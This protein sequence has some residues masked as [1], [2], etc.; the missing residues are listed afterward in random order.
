MRLSEISIRNFRRLEDVRFELD[1]EATLLVGPNNSGKTS[2]TAVFRCFLG[3]RAFSVHD[4]SVTRAQE[5]RAFGAAEGAGRL[6][7]IELDLWFAVDP[8]S[9]GYARSFPLLPRLSADLDRL[10]LRLA[11]GVRD[12]DELRGEFDSYSPAVDGVRSRDLPQF[13]ALG[14]NL[15]RHFQT[16][17]YSITEHESQPDPPE[18]SPEE[19]KKLLH[20]LLRVDFVDAQRMIDDAD[21]SRSNKLSDA[22]AG[23]YTRNL[24]QAEARAA[25]TE[26]IEANNSRLTEHYGEQFRPLIETIRGLGV[27]SV[28][29]REI[30]I[31]SSLSP[32]AA[33]RGNTDLLYVDAAR[34]HELPELYN[35]LGFKN[36]IYMA[37]QARDYQSQWMRTAEDRSLIQLLFIEEPEVHLH[38]QVQQVFI[39]NVQKVLKECA[40]SAGEPA[41]VPQVIITTHSSHIVNTVDFAKVRYFRRCP[42]AG[43]TGLQGVLNASEVVSLKSFRP[44]GE[45]GEPSPGQSG[46]IEFLKRYMRLTHCDLFFADAAILVEGAAERLLVPA[47]VP[48]VAGRLSSAYLTLLEVGG[49]HAGKFD[50]LLEFLRIPYLVIADLDSA[51]PSGS[52]AACRG[53]L[54]GAVTSNPTLRRLL[55]KSTV[56]ELLALG[57]KE[58]TD[59]QKGR[60]VA[61]QSGVAVAEGTATLTMIPRTLEEAIAYENFPLLRSGDV[62][63]G[64]NDPLPQPLE[65]AYQEIYQRIRSQGFKKV[66]FALSLLAGPDVWVPPAYITEALEWL[67]GRLSAEP[68][69]AH[70]AG[71]G[72]GNG[73]G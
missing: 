21:T 35:G 29:D 16:R 31:I 66:D 45:A 72:G 14:N 37:V 46:A 49:A 60:R 58:K 59:P 32:E 42:L 40:R 64:G 71:A 36:L 30:R 39:Q 53:D 34:G 10:G 13:L 28:N 26:V 19:G 68:A 52:H 33:L 67:S 5:M 9:V 63:L 41:L 70:P 3:K 12:A 24:E 7:R 55:G 4:F 6:P 17:Y 65:D 44:A 18:I 73:A 15:R 50:G 61:F 57:P 11:F 27:P 2:A 1:D 48:K 47:M 56:A 20:T 62:S 25:A 22:F 51:E 38:A 54:P 69:L 23:F 8:D 43:E